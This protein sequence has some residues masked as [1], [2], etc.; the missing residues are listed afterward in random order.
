[1]RTTNN[2]QIRIF[3]S[4]YKITNSLTPDGGKSIRRNG[5]AAISY[6]NKIFTGPVCPLLKMEGHNGYF[7]FA[8]LTRADLLITIINPFVWLFKID[9]AKR[10]FGFVGLTLANC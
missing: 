10:V 3:S 9:M 7:E 1:M 2:D 4:D 5:S 6:F 8:G